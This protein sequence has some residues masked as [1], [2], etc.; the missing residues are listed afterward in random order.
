MITVYYDGSGLMVDEDVAEHLKIADGHIVKSE[1]EFWKIFK[2]NR[3]AV[4]FACQ[5]R[6]LIEEKSWNACP[7]CGNNNT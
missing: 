6:L 4:I 1:T 5:A 2:S 3:K 7:H